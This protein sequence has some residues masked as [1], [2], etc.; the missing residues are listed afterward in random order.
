[1][2]LLLKAMEETNMKNTA[3]N[4][5]KYTGMV[6][7][8]QYIGTKKIK[9]MQKHNEGGPALF[10][11]LTDCLIGDFTKAH[12]TLP[13]K[14]ILLERDPAAGANKYK[15]KSGVIYLLSPAEK[16]YD[17][18]ES[19]NPKVRYSF[20]VPKEQVESV[21]FSE[22]S[23][24]LYNSTFND[25]ETDSSDALANCVARC[26]LDLLVSGVINTALVVDWEMSF[27]TAN[28]AE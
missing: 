26:D 17:H 13:N 21:D 1:M 23:I 28:D 2:A 24:G 18:S 14:I 25:Q 11:F 20:M 27:S 15:A 3:V 12:A 19:N 10:E 9:I 6:T 8:S 4:T 16:E 22:L 5:L 7:L